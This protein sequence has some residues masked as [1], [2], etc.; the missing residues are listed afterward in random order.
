MAPFKFRICLNGCRA[1]GTLGEE[2][3]SRFFLAGG[4][5]VCQKGM[6]EGMSRVCRKVRWKVSRKG[7]VEGASEGYVGRYV[8]AMVQRYVGPV[9][10]KGLSEGLSG[11]YVGE[12]LW[13]GRE[14]PHL[15]VTSG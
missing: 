2:I 14:S 7:V 8:G 11:V 4:G 5:G 3:L 13:V 12:W 15:G 1:P 6:S 10:R 9:C